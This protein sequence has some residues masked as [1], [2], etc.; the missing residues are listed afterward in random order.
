MFAF[1]SAVPDSHG[2]YAALRHAEG[3]YTA[4]APYSEMGHENPEHARLYLRRNATARGSDYPVLFHMQPILTDVR[5]IFDVG[6]N[7][8]NLFY[9]Y[10]K[11]LN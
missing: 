10:D 8:G 11:Y 9:C 6:D 4:V 2:I 7:V 5:R 3:A 1:S